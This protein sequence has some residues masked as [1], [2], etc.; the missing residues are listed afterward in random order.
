MPDPSCNPY[1]ALTVSLAAGLEG[2][3]QEMDCGPPVNKNIFEMSQRERRRLRID[4]LPGNLGEAIELM[5]RSKFV[6][7]VLGDHIFKNFVDAKRAEWQDYI[8]RVH[9]W[10]LDRYL[11]TY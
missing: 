6:R 5:A 8:A 4:S 3:A 1:L 7:E 11:A 10:E 2:V 9:S